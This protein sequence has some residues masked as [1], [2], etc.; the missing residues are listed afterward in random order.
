VLL[1]VLLISR[2]AF[3]PIHGV[4]DAAACERA[5]ADAQTRQDSIAVATLSYPDPHGHPVKRRCGE[6]RPGFAAG[7]GR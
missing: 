4:R 6:L 3:A 5:Y 1:L 2:L 7:P